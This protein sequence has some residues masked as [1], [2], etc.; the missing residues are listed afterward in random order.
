MLL[1]FT[2]TMKRA[3]RDDLIKEAKQI[4]SKVGS[5]VTS[6]TDYLIA[7]EKVG[8]TKINDARSKGVKVITEDEYFELLGL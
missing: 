6:K 3:K 7:G 2:G 5:S 1:V 4:G 8:E